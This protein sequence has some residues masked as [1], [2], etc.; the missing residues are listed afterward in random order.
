[1]KFALTIKNF[2]LF[3]ATTILPF[4]A[5]AQKPGFASKTSYLAISKVQIFV[6]SHGTDYIEVMKRVELLTFSGGSRR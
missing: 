2:L 5:T 1:M 6:L 3:C 4:S